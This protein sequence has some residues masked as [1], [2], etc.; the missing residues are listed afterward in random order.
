MVVVKGEENRDLC[1]QSVS[2]PSPTSA[3]S[4]ATA[5]RT[6]FSPVQHLGSVQ[7]AP[8]VRRLQRGLMPN[9]GTG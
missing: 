7:C 9:L 4:P 3:G 1:L 5:I 2:C 8:N 6:H